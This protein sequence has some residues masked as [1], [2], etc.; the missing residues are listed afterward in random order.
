MDRITEIIYLGP[1][2]TNT[3]VAAEQ[4][5]AR[6]NLARIPLTPLAS[7]T[8]IVMRVSDGGE[9][10]LAIVPIEN[11]IEGTVR[12][13]IDALTRTTDE[14]LKICAG[15]TLP[16]RHCLMAKP[17]T[18]LGDIKTVHS[19]P[20]ALAQC[21]AYITDAIG[22]PTQVEEKSTA[23]AA[24]LLRNLDGTHAAIAPEKAAELYSLDI[25]AHDIGD[26]R[27]NCTDFVALSKI[28][29]VPTGNDE[30]DIVVSTID[31]P[32]ALVDVLNIFKAFGINLTHI[33][34]RPSRDAD[35]PGYL[36]HIDF[37]GHMEDAHVLGAIAALRSSGLIRFFRDNGSYAKKS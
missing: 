26:V 28:A 2:G 23:A 7:I 20:H 13:T 5:A 37:E 35:Y 18:K 14:R 25:L 32:G 36:F 33:E 15:L 9:N 29:S 19:H 16:I 8:E 31:K 34:S 10:I 1:E 4:F 11:S 27:D 22:N 6:R 3:Q 12:E 21:R 17:G 30:T 24:Q